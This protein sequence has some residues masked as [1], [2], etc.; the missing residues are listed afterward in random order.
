[1]LEPGLIFQNFNRE[2]LRANKW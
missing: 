1:M 2:F